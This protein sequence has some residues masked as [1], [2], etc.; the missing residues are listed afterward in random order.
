MRPARGAFPAIRAWFAARPVRRPR[1]IFRWP[2]SRWHAS[3]SKLIGTAPIGVMTCACP[4]K[5][6]RA[7]GI[8]GAVGGHRRQAADGSDLAVGKC[9][10][11]INL[12]RVHGCLSAFGGGLMRGHPFAFREQKTNPSS[13]Q[14]C[15]GGPDTI[16]GLTHPATAHKVPRVDRLLGACPVRGG[17]VL[18]CTTWLSQYRWQDILARV[19]AISS[20]K[21]L[22]AALFTVAG[23]GC[24]TLYD[25]LA[26]RFA[27]AR[28]P[29]PRIA[30][31]SF[32]GYAIGH[33]VGLN[34]LSGGAIRYRAYTALGLGAT[35]I[36]TIIAFGTV[37]FLLGAGLLLGLSLLTQARHV[38]IGTACACLARHAGRES[39][40][41]RP[42]RRIC[43]WCAP[44]MS[45]CASAASSSRC[46]SRASPSRRSRWPAP[47]CLCAASVLYVLLPHQAAISFAAFAG[48]YLIAIAAGVISNVPGGIGVFEAVLLL[49]LPDVPKDR[50]LGAL[51]A[52]RA[53]YY[54]APFAL[55][56]ALLGI[57][58]LWAHRGPAVRV[59]Q[60]ARTFLIAVTPQAHRDRGVPRGRRAAV[61]RRHAR[62]RQPARPAARLPAA[63]HPRVV[64]SARQR[65]GRGAAGDCA[66]PVPA[67]QRRLVADD[68]AAVRRHSAVAAQ[69]LRLRRGH[70]SRRRRRGA[71][72]GPRP[73][74][75]ARVA[76]RTALFAVPGSSRCSWCSPPWPGWWYSPIGMCPTTINSGGNLPSTRRRRAACAPRCSP[77]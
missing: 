31:I 5:T 28:V 4:T 7:R 30:L 22:R 40:C 41:S 21:L 24:L 27:G 46:R 53:I 62:A 9:L 69:G 68:L 67:P 39:C 19:H 76:G 44:G 8:R 18:G 49:L 63:A 51:V 23:Y 48:I 15:L 16:P 56:L 10:F 75:A 32:M 52:Y 12:R 42:S 25:A 26:V 54:F 3:S 37:T 34:T 29:Y 71:G 74:S 57:H 20:A 11:A 47:I 13:L 65:R 6:D 43:G 55:A 64:A 58:E 14:R 50:L 77:P 60:L 59:V 1:R 35:Q 45:R 38:G 61:L 2:R 36:A 70:D 33:N 66:R 73:L 17:V 72:V